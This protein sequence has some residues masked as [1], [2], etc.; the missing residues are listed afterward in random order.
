MIKE[1]LI[2][3]RIA[4]ES[5]HK[6]IADPQDQDPAT[7]PRVEAHPA[8][9]EAHAEMVVCLPARS[10]SAVPGPGDLVELSKESPSVGSGREP[11]C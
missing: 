1:S 9:E 5:D 11:I 8:E 3:E 6:M 4:L 2:A 10:R 7:R